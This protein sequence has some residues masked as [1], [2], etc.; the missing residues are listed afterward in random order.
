MTPQ[1]LQRPVLMFQKRSDKDH[2][3]WQF[4]GLPPFLSPCY[5]LHYSIFGDLNHQVQLSVKWAHI[6][7]PETAPLDPIGSAYF[8]I[9]QTAIALSPDGAH[10]VYVANSDGETHLYLRPMYGFEA[11]PIPGTRGDIKPL[12][13]NTDKYKSL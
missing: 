7:L 5:W 6:K 2:G 12:T 1:E 10:L 13:K 11:V 4:H 9:G 3:F 8:S